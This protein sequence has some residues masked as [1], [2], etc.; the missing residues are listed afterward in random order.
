M[1]PLRT[2]EKSASAS[3]GPHVWPLFICRAAVGA[4]G[5]PHL[6]SRLYGS[7]RGETCGIGG[8]APTLEYLRNLR[9][10]TF[11]VKHSAA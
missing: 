2:S 4:A 6:A 7:L 3:C 8:K 11:L 5:M 1:L 10:K 9:S